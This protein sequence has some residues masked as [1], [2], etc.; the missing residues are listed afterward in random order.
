MRIMM[1]RL[2]MQAYSYRMDYLNYRQTAKQYGKQFS[3]SYKMKSR[4]YY[5]QSLR[6]MKKSGF[7]LKGGIRYMNVYKQYLKRERQCS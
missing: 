5:I 2:M 6:F 1:T 3:D 4:N 7:N